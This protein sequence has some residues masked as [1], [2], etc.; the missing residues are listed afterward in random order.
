MLTSWTTEIYV[1]SKTYIDAVSYRQV[2]VSDWPC[3]ASIIGRELNY[4]RAPFTGEVELV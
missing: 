1:I 2:Q 3:Q 4:C